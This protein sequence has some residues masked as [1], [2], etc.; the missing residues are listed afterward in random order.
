[1]CVAR[2]G[3]ITIPGCDFTIPVELG[4]FLDYPKTD[5]NIEK[6]KADA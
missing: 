1:M 5:H 6:V 2:Q 3:S 4:W